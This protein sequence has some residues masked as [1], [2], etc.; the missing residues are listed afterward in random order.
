MMQIKILGRPLFMKLYFAMTNLQTEDL[1][2][3]LQ[4]TRFWAQA[5]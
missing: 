1:Y 4:L 2:K 5:G 3:K